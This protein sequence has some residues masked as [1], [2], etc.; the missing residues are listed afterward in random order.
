[1]QN[2][3]SSTLGSVISSIVL[4]NSGR[5]QI[6]SVLSALNSS[7]SHNTS[8]IL[9]SGVT[10]HV[11]RIS[12]IFVSYEPC[13]TDRKVQTANGTLLTVAGIGSVKVKLIYLLTCTSCAKTIVSLISVQRF[14]KFNESKIIFDRIE[15]FLCN[16]V[17]SW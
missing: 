11:T 6:L 1:M 10:D 4:A 2:L 15:G 16:K 13:S 3:L 7:N 9:D 5:S 14:A 12:N 8:W 17:H